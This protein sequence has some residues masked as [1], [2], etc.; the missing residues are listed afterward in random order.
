M[1]EPLDR[2]G[3][4]GGAG[5]SFAAASSASNNE[6]AP[7]TAAGQTAARRGG[8][9]ASL[10]QKKSSLAH[11][12]AMGIAP[13]TSYNIPMNSHQQAADNLG[14]H[15]RALLDAVDKRPFSMQLSSRREH[16]QQLA[17]D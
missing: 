6:S 2:R 12:S 9:L 13:K 4:I 16:G 5:L 10:T 8:W 3:A 11:D 15:N 14:V 7:R 17:A 1:R